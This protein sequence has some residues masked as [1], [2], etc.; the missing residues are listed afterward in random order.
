MRIDLL[1][2]LRGGQTGSFALKRIKRK[3]LRKGMVLVAPAIKPRAV[4][5]FEAEIVVLHHPTTITLRYQV[6]AR[7]VAAAA[8]TVPGHGAHGQRATDGA[9]RRHGARP[10]ALWRQVPH[11]PPLHALPRVSARGCAARHSPPAH[12][13]QGAKLIFR[14]G[15]TKA[16]GT[17]TRL[18]DDQ[19][20][21]PAFP[22]TAATA[23]AHARH[24]E[25]AGTS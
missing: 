17:V 7:A 4:M 20:P 18:F 1:Q 16:V 2:E 12:A 11:P 5:D 25:A 13:A 9:D 23:A 19:H 22:V 24:A 14:E 15:R 3:D 6:R 8:M 10:A 21:A